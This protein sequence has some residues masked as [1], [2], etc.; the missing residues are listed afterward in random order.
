MRRGLL[1]GLLA[2]LM[3]MAVSCAKTAESSP[4]PTSAAA[5]VSGAKPIPHSLVSRTDCT[6]C[7]A[8]G[9]AAVPQMPANHQGRTNDVCTQCHRPIGEAAPSGTAPVVA[10]P[11]T[12]LHTLEGRSECL[13]CHATGVASAPAVPASHQGR[14]NDTCLQCHKAVGAEA[15]PTATKAPT[16]A[17]T[18]TASPTAVPA[19]PT[20]VATEAAQPTPTSPQAP[21]ATKAAE[22]TAT[23]APAPTATTPAV[24]GPP[25]IPHTL[26]GRSDCLMCHSVGGG[27]PPLGLPPD[28]QGR[29]SDIC[30]TCHRPAS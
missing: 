7:H 29:T 23:K 16:P 10:G 14:T 1:L 13:V 22:P 11:P 4:T 28:H 8:S 5:T 25:L 30:T 12:I 26:A 2:G 21:T 24:A 6:T 9:V 15:T 3:L 17:A 27:A 18:A 20:P 19:S